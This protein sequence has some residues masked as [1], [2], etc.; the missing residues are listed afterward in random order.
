[1]AT[2]G[3]KIANNLELTSTGSELFSTKSFAQLGALIPRPT[4]TALKS[5]REGV[6]LLV[7][8]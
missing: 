6:A 2:G 7:S 5:I 4:Q 1:M 8:R 3:S